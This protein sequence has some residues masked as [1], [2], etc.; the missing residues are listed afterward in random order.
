MKRYALLALLV[1]AL[2]FGAPAVIGIKAEA[3]YQLAIDRIQQS[4]VKVISHNYDR[5]WFGSMAETSLTFDGP[6]DAAA[7]G[8]PGSLRLT[9]LSTVSHG[10]VLSTG[11][12]LA[13][14]ES[15]IKF[16][17]RAIL[18]PDYPAQIHTLVDLNGTGHTRID[19]PA[20]DFSGSAQMPDISFGG[21]SGEVA[22]DIGGDAQIQFV[23]NSLAVSSA[24][25]KLVELGETRL[26]SNSRT[27]SS[28]LMLGDGEFRVQQ[29]VLNDPESGEQVVMHD[30][31][32]DLESSEELEQVSAVASYRMGLI[33]V[34]GDVY[35][36]GVLSVEMSRLP[37]PVLARLQQALAEIK[38]QKMSD[39]QRGMALSGLVM[40][41]ASE[42]LKN[43]PTIAIKPL[44][45]VTP[46]GTVEGELSLRGAGLSLAD[47]SSIP[48]LASK[49]VADL[50]LRM[51]EKLFR[52]ML[53]KQIGQQLEQQMAA[54]IE[55]GGEAP[56]LDRAQ[57]QQLVE[58]QVDEQLKHWLSQ[59]I[60][61]RDGDDLATVAS[62]SSGLLTVNGKTVP[63]S[64]Q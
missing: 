50:S 14:I 53:I 32:I 41:V 49:L 51:P 57:L 26:D 45:L 10:P 12:G 31:A 39:A 34:A 2:V 27:S 54:M 33:E 9:L 62:L 5:G 17:E 60:I 20:A 29:F 8:E 38:A 22:F 56:E 35:G 23:L 16:G 30:L 59:E 11:L 43:D 58:R 36:P 24:G 3:R 40:S 28:G 1:M 6:E 52:S 63:L 46:D 61:E 47:V 48:A 21:L 15:E 42:L 19:L 18:P 7:T 55:Q 44:R 37:G 4:G 13:E 64:Q 25:Q